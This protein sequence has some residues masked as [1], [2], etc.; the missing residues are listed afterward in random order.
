MEIFFCIL[1]RKQAD[2]EVI[3]HAE[4]P[5]LKARADKWEQAM[6]MEM[7]VTC[8]FVGSVLLVKNNISSVTVAGENALGIFGCAVQALSLTGMI[9]IAGSHTGA[10]LNPAVSLS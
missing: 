2:G 1:E 9:L 3:N 10:S 4:F 8:I 7:I 5:H 6:A